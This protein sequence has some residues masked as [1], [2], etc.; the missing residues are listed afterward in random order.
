VTE[1]S[2]DGRHG[3]SR[4]EAHKPTSYEKQKSQY[5]VKHGRRGATGRHVGQNDPAG[6]EKAL[7]GKKGRGDQ[8]GKRTHPA[9]PRPRKHQVAPANSTD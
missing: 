2:S 7:N 8:L 5:V 3:G 1:H 4:P 6:I 9:P